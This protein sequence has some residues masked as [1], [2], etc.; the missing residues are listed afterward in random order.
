MSNIVKEL[1]DKGIAHPPAWLPENTHYLTMMG[2]VAYGVSSDTSDS[3]I[4]GFAIPT[5]DELFPHLR[6]EIIGFGSLKHGGNRFSNYQEHHLKDPDALGGKGRDYDLNIYNIVDYFQ[7]CME[8]NP[9][10][11][12]SMFTPDF[13]VLHIT[14]IGQMVR[15]KRRIFLNKRSYHTFKGYAYQQLKKSSNTGKD[16]ESVIQIRE[17]ED[18]HGLNHK[19][20]FSEV[21]KEMKKRGLIEQLE[22]LSDSDL[23][24]YYDMYQK[25]MSRSKRFEGRKIHNVDVKF[26][27]HIARLADECE[28]IL[29]GGDIDLQRS[30]EYMKAIRRGDVSE[31]ELK[32]WFSDKEKHLEALYQSST[33]PYA[34]DEAV[35]K[36]LLFNCLEEHYG[37]LD[38]VLVVPDKLKEALLQIETVINN[39]HQSLHG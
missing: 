33:L 12:D 7:L 11:V 24:Q 27:Y 36:K 15:E 29:E 5:K 10:M 20:S 23:K 28:Q 18:Q 1:Y 19:V 13:C 34:P 16:A 8:N 22:K 30:R 25:G 3:D 6:G 35:I 32:R 31:Q 37:S 9:N 17:F 26:L 4:Y 38:K 2:S 21:E 14:R 39:I